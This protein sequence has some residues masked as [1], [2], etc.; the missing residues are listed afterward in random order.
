MLLSQPK[1]TTHNTLDQ[2][3]CLRYRI[4]REPEGRAKTTT[5]LFISSIDEKLVV[6]VK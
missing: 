5:F 1:A 6:E 2:I 3:A 4:N